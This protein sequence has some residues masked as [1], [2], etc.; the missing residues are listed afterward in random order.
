MRTFQGQNPENRRVHTSKSRPS[1]KK[2]CKVP[3][4]VEV[5]IIDDDDD[6]STKDY[7]VGDASKQLVLYNPEI[8]RDKQSDIDHHNSLR[9]SSKKPRYGYGTV[10]P[11]IGAYTVQCA[12]CYKWRIV[13]TKEKYEELRESISQ[14]LFVC[15]RVSEWNRELSC[16]EPE[17]IS[18]DGSRVWALDKPNIAQPPPGWDREVRIR[19]ASTKFAD[20]Y[21]TS[22]S[23][24]KLR[25]LVEIGRY[26]AENPHYIREGVNLSQFSFAIPKPLQED[27]VRKRRLRDAHELPELPE[28]AQVDPLC[29]AA[30]PIR[31]ELLAGPGSSTS[32]PAY[33]NQPEMPDPVDLHQPEV[34]EP[35]PQYHKKRN[36]K[37]VSSRK[38]QSNLPATSCPF[39]EQSGGYFID[40]D[41]VAL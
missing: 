24:K 39:E 25:S 6:D 11:S 15:T 29:W 17:D 8:T 22:P 34:S 33:S 10:L 27:Y 16:D 32:Y 7:S 9:Q 20:V 4:S 2:P 21:Y 1:K 41:H 36:R 18:Q 40:I 12:S 38:C 30:P 19:V 5:H 37:Q 28:I 35:P 14:E 13:P 31:R 26:L 3:E 23:G